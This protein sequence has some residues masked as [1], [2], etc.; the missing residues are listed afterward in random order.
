MASQSG[1][2]YN[3]IAQEQEEQK[4][5]QGLL[6]VWWYGVKGIHEGCAEGKGKHGEEPQ[7]EEVKAQS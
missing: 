3:N 4:Q 6:R 5:I 2:A 1:D 7:A